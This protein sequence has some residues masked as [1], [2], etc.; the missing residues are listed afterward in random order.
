MANQAPSTIP[1]LPL[2]TAPLRFSHGLA[3]PSTR[4]FDAARRKRERDRDCQRR[5]R[6]RDRQHTERL[7]AR[8]RELQGQLETVQSQERAGL[9]RRIAYPG[10]DCTATPASE[11]RSASAT[12]PVATGESHDNHKSPSSRSPAQPPTSPIDSRHQR[13]PEMVTVSLPVLESC[14]AAPQWA[15]LPLH[16]LSLMPDPRQCVRGSALPRF[17]V[18]MGADA[19]LQRFCPPHPKIIDIL[20]GGSE[21]PLANLIVNECSKEPLLPPER[22][23]ANLALYKY[24]RWLIWPSEESFACLP[25]YMHPTALQLTVE[26][27]WCI[28]LVLWPKLR[29]SMIRNQSRIDMDAAIGLFLCSLRIRGSFNTNFISRQNNGDLEISSDFYSRF[30]DPAHWGLLSTFWAEYPYLVEGL[31]SSV[32]VTEQDLLLL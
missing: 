28:D 20:Y 22:L 25:E 5:K 29:E 2:E 14:L 15:R 8:I 32:K 19:T 10:G 11:C 9:D 21:N 24:C 3:R 16:G 18:Q 31:D 7:E 27:Q 6:Q 4:S 12:R 13:S 1:R 26:H 17:I 23:A 30:T